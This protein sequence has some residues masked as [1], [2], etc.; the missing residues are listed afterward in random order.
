MTNLVMLLGVFVVPALLLVL[1]HK[2]RRRSARVQGL[3]WGALAGHLV[4]MVVGTAAGLMPPEAWQP[5]DVMR[6]ALSIW[7]FVLLPV[8]GGVVGLL[9]AGSGRQNGVG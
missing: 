4:A 5:D 7:S 2:F 9:R 6:G 3:F 8:V 1:G